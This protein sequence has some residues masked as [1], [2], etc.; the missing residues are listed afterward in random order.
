MP[1]MRLLIVAT[2]AAA[3]LAGPALAES[4]KSV[5]AS[6]SHASFIDP[7]TIRRQ[8]GA[9]FAKEMKVYEPRTVSGDRQIRARIINYEFECATGRYRIIDVVQLDDAA[10]AIETLDMNGEFK[11]ASNPNTVGEDL[12][13]AACG[14]E[15]LTTDAAM[16][17]VQAIAD[18]V[19]RLAK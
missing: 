12:A 11:D 14:V 19:G 9:A 6:S 7:A 2:L 15:P 4:W 3:A 5:S 10:A 1:A 18:G 8:G 13:Q 17:R 16:T